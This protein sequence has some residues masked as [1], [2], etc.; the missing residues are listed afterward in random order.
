MSEESAL[1]SGLSCLPI[2]LRPSTSRSCSQANARG[3]KRIP[4]LA[5]MIFLLSVLSLPAGHAQTAPVSTDAS[6][7]SQDIH[8]AT[9]A[10]AEDS[11]GSPPVVPNARAIAQADS[12]SNTSGSNDA[13]TNSKPKSAAGKIGQ[14][15]KAN[16][17]ETFQLDPRLQKDLTDQPILLSPIRLVQDNFASG[18]NPS[19][20]WE[21]SPGSDKWPTTYAKRNLALYF[22]G[23]L[24]KHESVWM[25]MTPASGAH[26]FCQNWELLKGLA[27]Y[28]TDKTFVQ[29]NGGLIFNWQNSGF[30]G[31]DRTVTQTSPGV[32][33]AFNG[34]D[35]TANSRGA[36]LEATG[37]NWTTGKIFAYV[38]QPPTA[39][40]ADPNIQYNRGYGGGLSFEK[41]FGKEGISGIQSNLTVGST[42]LFN[43]NTCQNSQVAQFNASQAAQNATNQANAALQAQADQANQAQVASDLANGIDPNTAAS[44]GQAAAQAVIANAGGFADPVAA[45]QAA[46]S[47]IP[48]VP[49]GTQ[50]SPFVWWTSWVNHSYQ[51]KE[52]YIRL[53]PSFG[54]TTFEVKRYYDDPGIPEQRSKGYGYTFDVMAVPVR[55]YWTTIL[56][57]DAFNASDL[58]HRNTQYTFTIGNAWDWHCGNKS[59]I[60]LTLDYQVVGQQGSTAD[61]RFIL[62]FW[63]IW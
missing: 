11:A 43:S 62:G 37:L 7:S 63:P 23:P 21:K 39:T 55:S 44:D 36:S 48:S 12:S 29:L 47:N 42:S 30:G 2:L 10:I 8:N 27:N 46:A 51:D 53:N 14:V 61:Q 59:R 60:R 28:G 17:V 5:G 54:L 13:V 16:I 38:Q 22:V 20:T 52:G 58:I 19:I 15:I 41:L 18:Y 45:G 35:P 49:I 56:R 50:T 24:T 57:M 31:A 9:K 6:L 3:G 25:Q 32:Y 33:T 40:S 26:G 34:F 4:C 1:R